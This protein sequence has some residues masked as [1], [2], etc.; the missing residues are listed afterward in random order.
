M[1][2]ALGRCAL[3]ILEGKEGIRMSI[4][5][6]AVV[7]V[8][9]DEPALDERAFPS[10]DADEMQLL[11]AHARVESYR[12]GESIFRAGDADIDFF[13]V[14]SGAIRILNPTDG[15]CTVVIH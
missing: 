4:A 13:V 7:A 9:V 15:N 6:D 11:A 3:E 2:H 1:P 5:D 14:Q 12:S 10:L 8:A